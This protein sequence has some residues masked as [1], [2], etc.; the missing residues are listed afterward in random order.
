M[1]GLHVLHH[2][3]PHTASLDSMALCSCCI[4]MLQ[5]ISCVHCN[6]ITYAA[7]NWFLYILLPRRTLVFLPSSFTGLSRVCC[8]TRTF[9]FVVDASNKKSHAV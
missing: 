2:A 9:F 3:V 7:A 4:I 1:T 8:N 6:I 5:S